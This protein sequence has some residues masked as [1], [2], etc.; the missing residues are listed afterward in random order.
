MKAWHRSALPVAILMSCLLA[1]M[2][3]AATGENAPETIGE[4]IHAGTFEEPRLINEPAWRGAV[5]LDTDVQPGAFYVAAFDSQPEQPNPAFPDVPQSSESWTFAGQHSGLGPDLKPFTEPTRIDALHLAQIDGKKALLRSKIEGLPS[6]QTPYPTTSQSN[7]FWA[8]IGFFEKSGTENDMKGLEDLAWPG[9]FMEYEPTHSVYVALRTGYPSNDSWPAP[10]SEQGAGYWKFAGTDSG[11]SVTAPKPWSARSTQ[12]GSY[13]LQPL[14]AV[15]HYYW[16]SRFT[17]FPALMNAVFPETNQPSD[18][19]VYQGRH[20]GSAIDPKVFGEPLLGGGTYR[21]R[22]AG[23]WVSLHPRGLE[24]TPS[25]ETPYPSE[26]KSND[27]WTLA[28][29][30]THAGTWQSPKNDQDEFTWA[31]QIHAQPQG[32]GQVFF[33][34]LNSHYAP[35]GGW[36]YTD[37]QKWQ[38]LGI[39]AHTGTV[40]D[41]KGQDELTWPGAVHASTLDGQTVYFRSLQEG[42]PADHDWPLPTTATSTG[43]W[44][45]IPFVPAP[46]TLEEPRRFN[47][48]GQPGSVYVDNNGNHPSSYYIS[49]IEGYPADD[50]DSFATVGLADPNWEFVGHHAGL[51]TDLKPFDDITRVGAFHEAE[52]AGQRA[53]VR[54]RITGWPTAATP[55]PV[56]LASTEHWEFLGVF[57]HA[58]TV[59]D[60]KGHDEMTWPGALHLDEAQQVVFAALQAGEPGPEG[61][62]YPEG[63]ESNDQWDFVI[64]LAANSGT[65]EA[66][67]ERNMPS[68]PGVIF[69]DQ[70]GLLS[71]KLYRS[72]FSGYAKNIGAVYPSGAESNEFYEYV[73]EHAGTFT[74]PKSFNEPTWPGAVHQTTIEGK[75]TFLKSKFEGMP[76]AETPYPETL[77][78]NAFWGFEFTTDQAGTY[79][80][81]KSLRGDTWPGAIHEYT[82]LDTNRLYVA[83]K[84]GNPEAEGWPSPAEPSDVY[85]KLVGNQRHKGTFADPKEFDEVTDIGLIHKTTLEGDVVY[86]RSWVHGQPAENGWDY[87]ET[88]ASNEYWEYLGSNVRQGTWDDPKGANDFTWPGQIHAFQLGNKRV[89]LISKVDGFPA[90]HDWSYPESEDNAYWSIAG[91]SRH[92]GSFQNPKDQQEV[93]WVGAVHMRQDGE[94]RMYYRS[95]VS[96]NLAAAGN[97]Y[98]LPEGE[99]SSPHWEYLGANSAAG[100]L[101]DPHIGTVLTWPGNMHKSSPTSTLNLYFQALFT[102]V[103]DHTHP[104]P[105]TGA[106]NADWNY[107]GQVRGAG[108]VLDPRSGNDIA[109]AGAIHRFERG[110]KTYFARS[111]TVGIPPSESGWVFPLPPTNNEQWEYPDMGRLVGNWG[112]PKTFIDATWPG[113]IHLK[114]IRINATHVTRYYYRSRIWGRAALLDGGYLNANK[115]EFIGKSEN[116]GT[117]ADPNADAV[118]TWPGAIHIDGQLDDFRGAMIYEA[119]NGGEIGID[120]RPPDSPE[121][122]GDD[123]R[124]VGHAYN[125]GTFE[126]P[127][128]WTEYTWLGRIHNNDIGRTILYFSAKMAGHPSNPQHPWPYP[129]DESSNEWWAYEGRTEH[130]GT[131]GSPHEWDEVTWPGAIHRDS[132]S[133]GT[134]YFKATFTG[135]GKVN[136]WRYPLQDAGDEHWT[137]IA[138]ATHAGTVED[139]R[140]YGAE[141]VWPGTI[142]VNTREPVGR[143]YYTA[144]NDGIPQDN[145][146]PLPEGAEGNEH[147]DY[148]GVSNHAGT[149]DDLKNTDEVTW[150]GAYNFSE[151]LGVRAFFSPTK[152]GVPDDNGWDLPDALASN[153]NWVYSGFIH[154]SGTIENPKRYNDYTE[155]GL[156]HRGVESNQQVLFA[157]RFQG[158]ADPPGRPDNV[159]EK[160]FPGVGADNEWWHF[161]RQGDGTVNI[162]NGW[163]DYSLAGDVNEYLYKGKRLLFRAK[164]EG[165]PSSHNRYYPVSEVDN[166]NWQFYSIHRGTNDDPKGWAEYTYI[167]DFHRYNYGGETSFFKAKKEGYPVNLGNYPGRGGSNEVWDYMGMHAGT[168]QDPKVWEEP[169]WPGAIH[170]YR[171]KSLHFISRFSGYPSQHN[172][173]YPNGA[174]SDANWTHLDTARWTAKGVNDFSKPFDEYSWVTAHNAFIGDRGMDQT[175]RDHFNRGVRAFMMDIHMQ[176]VGVSDPGR[177]RVCHLVLISYCH[178]I[179]PLLTDAFAVFLDLLKK[180]RDAVITIQFDSTISRAEMKKVVDQFPELA[181]YSVLPPI[182]GLWPT[183]QQMIDTNKRLVMFSDY[184]SWGTFTNGDKTV[185]ILQAQDTQ[186]ENTFNIGTTVL[187]HNWECKSRYNHLPLSLRKVYGSF[188][189]PFVLN[190]FH[191]GGGSTADAGNLDNNLTRLQRRVERFCGG[192]SGWRNPN[193]L[194]I[195]FNQVGDAFPYVA[196]MTQGGFYFYEGNNVDRDRDTVCVL[197]GG[198]SAPGSG[199]HY[200]LRLA[201]RGCEEDEIR[202]MELDGISAG[203]RIELYDSPSADRQDDFTII[204]V[205]QSVPLGQ[206]VR[207][208]SLEGS[209]DNFWYRKLAFRNNGLDGK[210]SRIKVRTTPETEDF[211]DAQ[212]VFYEEVNAQQN[213][214]CTVPFTRQNVRAGHGNNSYGC[215]NDE[216]DSAVIVQAKAGSYFSVVGHDHGE[217]KQGLAEVRVKK[218]ILMPLTIGNFES[219]FENEYVKVRRCLGHKLEG[220]ISYLYFWPEGHALDCGE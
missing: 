220:K 190:Q 1:L 159:P 137:Y 37:T 206:R 51:M 168:R 113:A 35:E 186:V 59:D 109:I 47:D 158:Q 154:T 187:I 107:V 112:E 132:F 202:S 5:F 15:R 62:M 200:D 12:A 152:A 131:F 36:Q 54:S 3:N 140:D 10:D 163:Y 180:N 108:T 139:P 174:F 195:D 116:G 164:Y 160:R 111:K 185:S 39:S 32:S 141:P 53:L 156:I 92:S 60:F 48:Y 80:D 162:P 208:N 219:S 73:G 214:V 18:L 118:L 8:F 69:A 173:Y 175:L 184:G 28:S 30:S 91:E 56:T 146:W 22:I 166:D 120:I 99:N 81:P 58:G 133:G 93:T 11:I 181:T 97:D 115:F 142:V 50:I 210:I 14:G 153:E 34:S 207:I 197:P 70:R 78:S 98:P 147:W 86:L 2:L 128:R 21:A 94:T 106:S 201:T 19:W 44:Q 157:S 170:W 136:G 55:Y 49:H 16:T 193:F 23:K 176:G 61:W 205:K 74:D 172:F 52:I 43:H 122:V 121:G 96:G 151:M 4:E 105:N 25:S 165:R 7:D 178:E 135:I 75:L 64:S 89:Y 76:S 31:G 117:L 130:A 33:R 110:G 198:Q 124:V 40:A 42:N 104:F 85:W 90:D 203:T 126:H 155:P 123:W 6:S 38:P 182:S 150:P 217:Y 125:E 57:K 82:Y 114:K 194:G 183:L 83:Q 199:V 179:D 95:R 171:E 129:S 65:V 79:V 66:P 102:G 213:I 68:A 103:A 41:P 27:Y 46:G 84:F 77:S 191:S 167:G 169:T 192:L 148:F 161:I 88:A 204:D 17:G 127:K 196:A 138:T 9:V 100:T 144:Q 177:V 24:G 87:P 26:L 101:V 45:V 145:D 143:Y 119:R 211:A 216:I 63:E 188:N 72:K 71:Q 209:E 29:V 67:R 134:R 212:V 218:D 215:D 13:Y 189:R 149:K 20:A